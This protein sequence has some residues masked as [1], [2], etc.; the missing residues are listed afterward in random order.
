[1]HFTQITLWI[2]ASALHLLIFFRGMHERALTRYKAFYVYIGFVSA[3]S[4][5]R[6]C[7]FWKYGWY[8]PHYYY[9]YHLPNLL[10]PIFQLLVLLDL[11]GRFIGYSKISWK[12]RVKFITV[13]TLMAAPVAWKVF[14]VTSFS[15]FWR[16]DTFMLLLQVAACLMVWHAFA[17]RRD[18]DFGR[19]LKGIMVGIASLLAFQA[20]NFA[21]LILGGGTYLVFM[22][23]TQFIYFLALAVFAYTLWT[24]DPVRTLEPVDEQRFD[25]INQDLQQAVK[26]FLTSR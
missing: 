7:I 21:T 13:A 25:K 5:M 20:L 14:T 8:S 3:I 19:N 6:I 4:L 15:F 23:L 26:T 10:M 16:Y 18:T 9:A 11:Y 2:S 1:M 24:F 22:F 12:K 17:A